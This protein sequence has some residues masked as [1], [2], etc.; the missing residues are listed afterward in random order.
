MAVDARRLLPIAEQAVTIAGEIVKTRLPGA[1]T[2]KGDRDMATEVDYAVEHAARDFLSRET[3]EI[4]FVG[5][6]EGAKAVAESGLKWVLDPV[7]GTV[8]FLHG[9]PLA[10]LRAAAARAA[11]GPFSR[12]ARHSGRPSHQPSPSRTRSMMSIT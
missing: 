11:W 8:D 6:E 12:A 2:A 9:L 7:D 4:G 10:A 1:V 3:P 5:E